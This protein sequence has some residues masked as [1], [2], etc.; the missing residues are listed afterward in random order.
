MQKFSATV[1]QSF[2]LSAL[3][4]LALLD[5]LHEYACGRLGFPLAG[6]TPCHRSALRHFATKPYV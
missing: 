1:A 3:C 2:A 6:R 5:V 4:L